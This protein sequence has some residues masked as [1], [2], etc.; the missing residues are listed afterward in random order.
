MSTQP[1]DREANTEQSQGT[2]LP[3]ASH[4]EEWMDSLMVGPKSSVETFI[5]LLFKSWLVLTTAV[6][7]YSIYHGE[8]GAAVS[9]VITALV[10]TIVLPAVSLWLIY[11]FP[12]AIRR[13]GCSIYSSADSIWGA[14][15]V[16]VPL[17]MLVFV[18]VLPFMISITF[19]RLTV[20]IA[21]RILPSPESLHTR[22]D[23]IVGD[24]P[25][26]W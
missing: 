20:A 15:V 9:G 7:A 14:I 5:S 4:W 25:Q 26:Y 11:L 18:W 19:P 1:H 2:P 21:E 12:K 10:V 3:P 17:W 13:A 23:Y 6:V 24:A 16:L 22:I 8:Y